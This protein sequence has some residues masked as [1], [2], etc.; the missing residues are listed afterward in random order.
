MKKSATSSSPEDKVVWAKIG[1][2]GHLCVTPLMRACA[3]GD[4]AAVA[5]ELAAIDPEQL[6]SE[7]GAGDDWAVSTPLHWASYSG[8]AGI[9]KML[10]E[11]RSD[12]AL[13]NGRGRALPLHLAARYNSQPAAIEVMTTTC[14]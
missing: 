8:N 3:K 9:V 5:E 2:F 6:G 12:P 13:K 1:P 4:Q 7:L 14:M 11:K 10:L